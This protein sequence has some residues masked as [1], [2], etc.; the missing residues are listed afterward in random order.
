MKS[1]NPKL[2]LKHYVFRSYQFLVHVT[3]NY[4]ILTMS[5]SSLHLILQVPFSSNCTSFFANY[6]PS[7]LNV[8]APKG[9]YIQSRQTNLSFINNKKVA[10]LDLSQCR[11]NADNFL[12][13]QSTVGGKNVRKVTSTLQGTLKARET[14]ILVEGWK[15]EKINFFRES[16]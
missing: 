2:C 14:R 16:G 8:S 13:I 3:F 6:V 12:H 15:G 5:F 4:F 11:H 10:S 7:K 9:E 1:N